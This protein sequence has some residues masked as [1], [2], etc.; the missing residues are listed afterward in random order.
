MI[1]LQ[2]N[3]PWEQ[4]V[5]GMF[6]SKIYWDTKFYPRG[7]SRTVYGKKNVLLKYISHKNDFPRE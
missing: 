7:P 2:I 3:F 5:I 4:K 6:L 1:I